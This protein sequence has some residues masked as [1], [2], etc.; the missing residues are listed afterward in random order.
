MNQDIDEFTH[1]GRKA[2]RE[3][4]EMIG[5]AFETAARTTGS[6]VTGVTQTAKHVA[7][8]VTDGVAKTTNDTLR[9]LRSTSKHDTDHS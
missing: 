5:D 9:S 8:A 3:T 6:V 4:S 7:S 2:I 1:S